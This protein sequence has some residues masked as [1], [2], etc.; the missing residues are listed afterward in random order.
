[1]FQAKRLILPASSV[2]LS[3]IGYMRYST[4]N[5]YYTEE[6]VNNHNTP[7]DAW[8]TYKNKVYNITNFIDAHPGGKEQ[9]LMGVGGPID[10]YWN[11]Y[12]QHQTK[13]VFDLLKKYEIGELKDYKEEDFES[14]Y[15][16]EP[17]R[18]N[19]NQIV[20][21]NEP[22]NAELKKSCILNNYITPEKCWFTRNHHPVPDININYYRLKINN[23]FFKY[24]DIVHLKNSE[25][26]TTI[27]CA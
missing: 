17:S 23:G 13:Y 20:H 24:N 6:E 5:K 12:K 14:E 8:V 15:D 16:N 11:I 10:I 2:I 19:K 27:Q 1:M 3:S 22:Y 21:K 7:N 25:I 18:E 4:T 26:T 9:I